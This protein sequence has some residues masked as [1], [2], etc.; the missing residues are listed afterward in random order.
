MSDNH[1]TVHGDY[2]EQSGNLG[3]GHVS[4]SEIKEK[5]ELGGVINEAE[6]HTKPT[7]G[8]IG[9]ERKQEEGKP[10]HN[11][12]QPDYGK[13]IGRGEEQ[14]K[15]L[16]KL[17]PYPHSTNS[18]ITIDGIGGIG[19]SA[20]AL[21]V[22]LHFLRNY[23]NLP[24]KER[25]DAIVWTSAKR[26][27][28]K[29]DRGIIS[30]KKAFKNLDD[31]CQTIA[32]VLQIEELFQTQSEDRIELIIDKLTQKRTLL[33]VD[34]LET[35]DDTAVMEFIQDLLPAP[36]KA[37]VTTRH[38]IDVA[39]PIRL[40]G[41]PWNDAEML[42]QQ[43]CQKKEVNLSN[44]QKRKLFDRT[45]GVP[46][47][48]VWSIAQVGFGYRM[49]SILKKLG[50]HEGNLTRFCFRETVEQIRGKDAY[51]LLLALALCKDDGSREELGY[52]AGLED[53]EWS[54]DDG[55]VELD[56]LSFVN[57]KGNKFSLL[58]LTKEY[59]NSELEVANEFVKEAILRLITYHVS[60]DL[61]LARE[62]L[63]K[64]SDR[65]S[66]STRVKAL[67]IIN[68]G[69]QEVP[70]GIV[71]LDSPFYVERPPIESYCYSQ[72]MKSGALIRIKGPR[73]IGKSSLMVRIANYASKRGYQTVFLD[74]QSFDN[75]CFANISNFLKRFCLS[76]TEK[77]GL[78]NKLYDYWDDA[79]FGSKISCDSYMEDYLLLQ[80]EKPL[81]LALDEVDLVFQ[82]PEVATEFLQL[83]R[84]WHEKSKLQT[85][86][87]KLRLVIAHSQEVYLPLKINQ[88][89]FNVG[90]SVELTEFNA[91]QVMDLVRRHRLNLSVGQVEL[92]MKMCEGYPYLIRLALY[93]IAQGRTTLEKFLQL[94]PTEEGSYTEHLRRHLLNLEQHSEL[95]TA[96]KVLVNSEQPVNI[97]SSEAFKLKGMGLV[98]FRG[99]QVMPSCD[100]YRLYFQEKL[101][102]Q[103]R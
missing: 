3:A 16:A 72:I 34:N 91:E 83:L 73:Q 28:L 78:P 60:R 19:K 33:I 22:S 84:S 21:E 55:L 17:R 42:I 82:H 15:I 49:N 4:E 69:I 7:Q 40:R 30:R 71:P 85:T 61:D 96:M 75:E 88:S 36:T 23:K 89:P 11:L 68:Y 35:V 50:N 86:W 90:F 62:Y 56:K 102:N 10:C 70:Q 24:L 100:L 2:Y 37:I 52:I 14:T 59:I 63:E 26:T 93:E 77:L 87:Q 47:A 20:L 81:I 67:N 80:Q 58:P 25:F 92:L 94:A 46:L 76:L 53:D 39:Y 51:N 5:A 32:I 99:N 45:G 18:V 27:C 38:R 95:L 97:S 6:Q 103:T 101:I 41:M 64:Y 79:L 43:E 44:E 57:K 12:P 48:I 13:F 8:E 98:K 66:D 74:F 1:I 54:R 9:Q 65:L 29:P 31:I